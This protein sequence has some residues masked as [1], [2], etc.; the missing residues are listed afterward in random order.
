M[1]GVKL[2]IEKQSCMK[3]G[4]ANKKGILLTVYV[5]LVGSARRE[6]SEVGL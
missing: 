2:D 1:M 5:S 6:E 4:R 3:R